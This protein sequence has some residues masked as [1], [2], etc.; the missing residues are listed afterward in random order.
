M[1]R[2]KTF[3]GSFLSYVLPAVLI[4][5][6]GFTLPAQGQVSFQTRYTVVSAESP[7]DLLE[8][9][10]RLHF[11]TPVSAEQPQLTTG[12]FAFHPAFP[13]LAAKIDAIL[14]RTSQILNI[15]PSQQSPLNIV[16]VA[17]GKEVR[18]RHLL[19]VPG[20]RQGLFG[21][22]SLEAFYET[23]SRTIYLSLRDLHEGILAHEMAHDLLCTRVCPPPAAADQESWAHFVESRL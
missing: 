6:W 4:L 22:G 14:V 9:E 1:I 5:M 16:L 10:R 7:T 12:E 3:V 15:Q 8:M 11:S 17:D 13:R 21:F 23:Y 20:Q 19:I 2:K 18:Q